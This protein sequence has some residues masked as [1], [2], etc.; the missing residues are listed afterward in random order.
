MTSESSYLYLGTLNPKSSESRCDGHHRSTAVLSVT[1]R[2][3]HHLNTSVRPFST[4]SV[5][6]ECFGLAIINM[7]KSD[8]T[9]NTFNNAFSND[10]VSYEEEQSFHAH[11]LL[12]LCL[13]EGD[14]SL[15]HKRPRQNVEIVHHAHCA[16]PRW[17]APFVPFGF[18][19]VRIH[20]V[21][22]N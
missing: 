3:R 8:Y 11:A 17:A 16:G 1:V 6:Q 21:S 7:S 4:T 12:G 19:K 18:A 9:T 20:L 22:R 13:D 5:N 14:Y 10:R 15:P 2:Y